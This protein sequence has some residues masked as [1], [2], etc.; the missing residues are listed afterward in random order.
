MIF[1]SVWLSRPT[2]EAGSPVRSAAV[3]SE[4]RGD[5]PAVKL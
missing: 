5:R 1:S 4:V 3:M 2:K